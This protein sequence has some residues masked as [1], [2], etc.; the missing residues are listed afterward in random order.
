MKTTL[1]VLFTSWMALTALV[2]AESYQSLNGYLDTIE[3][4]AGQTAL[5]I[6]VSSRVVLGVQSSGERA[7][8]FRFADPDPS[9]FFQISSNRSR[10]NL[11]PTP[12]RDKPI[13]IPGP[14]KLTLRTDGFLTLVLPEKRMNRNSS[15][16][17]PR[18]RRFVS[19]DW[20]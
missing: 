7:Q 9:L 17:Q 20:K 2:Q 15:S 12:T 19:N 8:Q 14:A 11:F 16:T 3:I 10:H 6:S 1:T 5:I 13:Y 4:P 18:V